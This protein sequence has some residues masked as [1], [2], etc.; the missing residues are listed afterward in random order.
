MFNDRLGYIR[1]IIENINHYIKDNKE[2]FQLP[3]KNP[4]NEKVMEMHHK[5]VTITCAIT[6]I[7]LKYHP[8]RNPDFQNWPE[9]L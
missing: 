1:G 4:C 3:L 6:N 9:F 2:Y 5:I 7:K 8:I